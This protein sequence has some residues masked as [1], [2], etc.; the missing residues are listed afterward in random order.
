MVED[1]TETP[2]IHQV[3]HN[4][5]KGSQSTKLSTLT[6]ASPRP[7]LFASR[8]EEA[9]EEISGTGTDARSNFQC[10]A[11]ETKRLKWRTSH[12]GKQ[13]KNTRVEQDRKQRDQGQNQ[14]R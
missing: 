6:N 4:G 9:K 5:T 13:Y 2:L 1:S 12:C 7:T 3:Q 8:E 11:K 10:K 14:F